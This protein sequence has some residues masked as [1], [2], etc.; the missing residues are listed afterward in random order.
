MPATIGGRPVS[1]LAE[2]IAAGHEVVVGHVS[3][4]RVGIHGVRATCGRCGITHAIPSAGPTKP[5]GDFLT[6]HY[7]CQ[8]PR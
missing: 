2:M 4:A 5:A 3:I 7:D 1:E 8:V 6:K